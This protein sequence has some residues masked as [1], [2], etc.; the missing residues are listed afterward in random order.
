MEGALKL[1]EISYIHA[2]GLCFSGELKHGPI[3]LVDSQ[4]VP[5][6][7]MAPQDALFDKTVSNMQEVMARDGKI[8]L[9]TDRKGAKSAGDGAWAVDRDA[10][11]AGFAGPGPL[12]DPG[13][14]AGLSYGG[15][16]GHGC[17]PAKE[18]GK[19]GDGGVNRRMRIFRADFPAEIA[20]L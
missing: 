18:P 6:I 19:V 10:R 9:V 2:E 17:G 7:V 16:Q 8:V 5:V 4:S 13:P 20:T 3:A 11:G 1:K 15:G 12:R 14:V